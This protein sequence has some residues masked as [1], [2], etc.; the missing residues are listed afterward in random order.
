MAMLR[1][2]RLDIE[3]LRN[4]S[5]VYAPA[6]QENPNHWSQEERKWK[7]LDSVTLNRRNK[8]NMKKMEHR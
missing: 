2:E 6:R 8:P 1:H 5:E 3:I 4:R 7:H